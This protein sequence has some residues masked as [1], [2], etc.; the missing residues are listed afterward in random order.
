M[1]AIRSITPHEYAQMVR[2]SRQ[3]VL[4]DVR[5][6]WEYQL[7]RINDAALMPLQEIHT[8][9][10]SLSRD[11]VYVVMCHHGIRSAYACQILMGMGFV[12][13]HNLA[14]GIDAW[15]SEVDPGVLKY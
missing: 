4:V 8:W 15:S 9:S 10:L 12:E 14:G 13:V 5:Q 2:A 1:N 6:P 7:A 11:M 3:H